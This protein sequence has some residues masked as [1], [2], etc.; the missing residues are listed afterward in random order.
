MCRSRRGIYNKCVCDSDLQRDRT[1][2]TDVEQK[3]PAAI[4]VVGLVTVAVAGLLG[5]Q[6]DSNVTVGLELMFTSERASEI[7]IMFVFGTSTV[8]HFFCGKHHTQECCCCGALLFPRISSQGICPSSGSM[9][10]CA[11]VVVYRRN[12]RY[13]HRGLLR[14]CFSDHTAVHDLHREYT[15]RCGGKPSIN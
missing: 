8:L 1:G 15:A 7:C 12:C 2:Y 10:A 3:A 13:M 14:P 6:G 9:H 5:L 4:F 11:C